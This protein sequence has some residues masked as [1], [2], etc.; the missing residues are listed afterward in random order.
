M[1]LACGYHEAGIGP[2]AMADHP[3]RKP[4]PGMLIEAG[5]RLDLDLQRSLIVGDKLADMQA[6]RGAGLAQGWLVDGEAAAQPGFAIK[7]LHDGDDLG[8]LL[9]AVETLGRG[10]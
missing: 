5:K 9:T 1:V 4:N 7:R 6:G 3:M 10:S 2:L 8:G